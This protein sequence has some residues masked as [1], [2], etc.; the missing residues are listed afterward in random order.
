MLVCPDWPEK[1]EYEVVMRGAKGVRV[2][3]HLCVG[4]QNLRSHTGDDTFRTAL[5]KD[6][7][8][9]CNPARK[10]STFENIGKAHDAAT[11]S[12]ED[13]TPSAGPIS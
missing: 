3:T 11:I 10:I 1:T 6:D 8:A 9:G 4:S 7:A 12:A 5:G 13:I 2:D